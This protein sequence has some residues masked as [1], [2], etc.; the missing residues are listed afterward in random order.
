MATVSSWLFD[1]PG[2]NSKFCVLYTFSLLGSFLLWRRWQRVPLKCLY[3]SSNLYV[4]ASHKTVILMHSVRL[5]RLLSINCVHRL[6]SRC[7]GSTAGRRMQCTPHRKALRTKLVMSMAGKTCLC[8][9]ASALNLQPMGYLALCS[10]HRV[11][12]MRGWHSAVLA[13][14]PCWVSVMVHGVVAHPLS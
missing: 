9:S 14:R 1:I 7:R 8:R 3:L 5:A 10:S 6:R 2:F 13:C 4:V 12:L 11:T